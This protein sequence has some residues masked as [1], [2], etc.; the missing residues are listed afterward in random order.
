MTSN[1]PT[2]A[3]NPACE[4]TERANVDARIL[5]AVHAEAEALER[6]AEERRKDYPSEVLDMMDTD[7]W[8]EYVLLGEE[9]GIDEAQ[10]EALYLAGWRAK[11]VL[12]EAPKNGGDQ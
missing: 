4:D 11:A 3:G 6:A 7:I 2:E 12:R 1:T 5:H 9:F 8:E 10:L